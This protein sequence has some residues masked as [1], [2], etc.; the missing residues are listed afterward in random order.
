MFCIFTFFSLHVQ[1]LYE[2]EMN[3]LADLWNNIHTHLSLHQRWIDDF[4]NRLTVIEDDR[5]SAI[6]KVFSSYSEILKS[7]AHMLPYDLQNHLDNEAQNINKVLLSNRRQYAELKARLALTEVMLDRRR[8]LNYNRRV[9]QWREHRIELFVA[10][11]KHYIESGDI[12][13]SGEV[14]DALTTIAEKQR[15]S[16]VPRVEL[17]KNAMAKFS[18]PGPVPQPA[19]AGTGSPLVV[20]QLQQQ[21]LR[22]QI[23]SMSKE[24]EDLNAKVDAA[25]Q[26]AC[27]LLGAAHNSVVQRCFDKIK[28]VSNTL[29]KYGA[30]ME[31]E[32]ERISHTKLLPYVADLQRKFETELNLFERLMEHQHFESLRESEALMRFLLGAA[33]CWDDHEIDLSK[34]ERR[35][36]ERLLAVRQQHDATIQRSETRLDRALDKLRQSGH[37]QALQQNLAAAL[38]QLDVIKDGHESFNKDT[39]TYIKAFPDKII[40]AV[41]KYEKE[42]FKYMRICRK[43]KNEKKKLKRKKTV[44]GGSAPTSR[45]PSSTKLSTNEG[46]SSARKSGRSVSLSPSKMLGKESTEVDGDEDAE[47]IE[48][49]VVNKPFEAPDDED[50]SVV[51]DLKTDSKGKSY[52]VVVEEVLRTQGG[53][54]LYVLTR[55]NDPDVVE[56]AAEE[57]GEQ[58]PQALDTGDKFDRPVFLSQEDMEGMDL[59]L[60]HFRSAL[61]PEGLFKEIKKNIRENFANHLEMWKIGMSTRAKQIQQSKMEE[62]QVEYELRMQLHAPRATIIKKDVHDVRMS[63]LRFHQQ[64]VDAHCAGTTERLEK[65]GEQFEKLLSTHDK[66]VADFEKLVEKMIGKIDEVAKSTKLSALQKQIQQE[67]VK[68]MDMVRT[69]LRDMRR[70]LENTCNA[71]RIANSDLTKNFRLFSDGGN[72]S[73]EEIGDFREKLDHL[74]KQIDEAEGTIMGEMEGIEAK[75]LKQ[76]SASANNF[77]ELIKYPMQDLLFLEKVGQIFSNCQCK[78]KAEASESNAVSMTIRH[79]I[80]R[81]DQRIDAVRR[82]N[83]EKENISPWQVNETLVEI[84][85]CCRSRSIYLDCLVAPSVSVSQTKANEGEKGSGSEVT[86]QPPVSLG[87]IL[88]KKQGHKGKTRSINAIQKSQQLNPST[89]PNSPSATPAPIAAPTT[90]GPRSN[91]EVESFATLRNILP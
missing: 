83:M 32:A 85:D 59:T 3:E 75:R 4:R 7:I 86:A 29:V 52:Q 61:V 81:L 36:D 77:D 63:E 48:E 37:A 76:C 30:A 26:E 27:H 42:M 21:P 82:P 23:Q 28:T 33:S 40:D 91:K 2:F 16:N 31:S 35:L 50:N 17:L 20:L 13:D 88:S 43:P 11:F 34:K 8:F 89:V 47:S 62:L 70:L 53:D 66:W 18:P 79:H 57:D 24:L 84:S 12:I 67:Q 71:L 45:V 19:L 90:V 44:E 55:T 68:T 51:E 14:K 58:K 54:M 69:S 78:V 1:A 80:E 25:N 9:R 15:A 39:S 38:K 73:P 56:I 5:L 49:N 64:R 60:P 10:E 72:F 46:E 65:I 22:P 74:G 41:E 87:P 6:R